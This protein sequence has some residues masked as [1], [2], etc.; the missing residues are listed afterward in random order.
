MQRDVIR[1][2][3]DEPCVVRLDKGAQGIQREGQYGVDYQYT[4]NGDSAVMWLPKAGRDALL[5]SGAQ[6][7]EQVQITKARRGREIVFFVRRGGGDAPPAPGRPAQG[8]GNGNGTGHAHRMPPRAWADPPQETAAPPVA[9]PSFPPVARQ[10]ASCL[11]AAIDAAAEAEVY[12]KSKGL[13][14]EFNA[15]DIRAIALSVYIG[16]QRNGG[17]Q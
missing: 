12:A 8:N 4:C 15:G 2:Q 7:G 1:L 10:L 16:A 17:K 11:C 13:P 6:P 5:Q 14:V 9:A 3:F